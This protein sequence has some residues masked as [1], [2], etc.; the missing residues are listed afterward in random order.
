M[1]RIV[2]GVAAAVAVL[3]SGPSVNGVKAEA[4]TKA[5][6][7]TGTVQTVATRRITEAQYKRTIA[8]LFG[9]DIVVNGRFEPE[10]REH[11]LLAIGSS[12]LSIS[13]S[14]F[15]QYFAIGRAISE[16]VLDDKHRS[17]FAT[18]M[19]ASVKG[20]DDACTAE[21]IRQHGRMLF[22]RPLTAQEVEPRVAVAAAGAEQAQ[23]YYAGLKLALMSLVTAPQFLFRMETAETNA[24]SPNAARLDG[25]TKAARLSYLLWNT[26][27]DE[28][29]LA[30]AA[31]GEFHTRK[32]LEKQVAR[33]LASPR[34]EAGTRAF[35]ADML[36]LDLYESVTKDAMIYPKFS[37]AVAESAKEQTLKTVVDQ[38]LTQECGL[39]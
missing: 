38:L 25:Y 2:C 35:F 29:L 34:L 33:L 5:R 13:A 36:Q 4:S 11:L 18:C 9:D 1:K 6:T 21:F 28:A 17:K 12:M 20:R 7:T 19:P 23:D 26:T 3:L 37:Q 24:G 10:Q 39:P 30:A 14:G 8:D 27:P 22:R 15:D 31:I 32:G 16:Q